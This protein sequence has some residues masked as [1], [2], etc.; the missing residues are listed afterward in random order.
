ML[1]LQSFAPM[2]QIAIGLQICRPAGRAPRSQI[3]GPCAEL[4]NFAKALEDLETGLLLFYYKARSRGAGPAAEG[5]TCWG[6]G[7]GAPEQ[8]GLAGHGAASQHCRHT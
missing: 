3:S 1:L 2:P 8:C 6:E 5:R 7:L 4:Y